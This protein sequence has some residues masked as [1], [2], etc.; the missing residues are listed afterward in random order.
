MKVFTRAV[1]CASISLAIASTFVALSHAETKLD[2]GTQLLLAAPFPGSEA[3]TSLQ[4]SASIRADEIAALIHQ[5]LT[6]EHA[7]TA[8]YA[9]DAI[10]R[11][12]LVRKLLAA[13]GD[14]Y[15]GVWFDP[16]NARLHV[17]LVTAGDS[18]AAEAA[19]TRVGLRFAIAPTYVRSTWVQ[20]KAAQRTWNHRL[21]RLF[22]RAEVETAIAPQHNAVAITLASS[23]PAQDRAAL[24][25][26]AARSRVAT[27]FANAHLP[28]ITIAR[29]AETKC[30]S[31][32]SKL[33]YCNKPITPGVSI[34][35]HNGMRCT[36]GPLVIPK[37]DKARTY[38][39]TA[40][41]CIFWAGRRSP[42]SSWTTGSV[43]LEIGTG[44]EFLL[45]EKGDV[46]AVNVNNPGN[47][48]EAGQTPVFA[49]TA[50]WGKNEEKSF[51]VQGE[52]GPP[53]VGNE[54]CVQGQTSG[55]TCGKIA[56]IG[57]TYNN[58]TVGPIGGLV[59][60]EGAATS[61]PGDSGGP[62]IVATKGG[63]LVEGTDV[64]HKRGRTNAIYEPLETALEDLTGLD[65]ELLTTSNETRPLE[66]KAEKEAGEK[67]ETKETAEK[68][69]EKEKK[70]LEE[71]GEKEQKTEEEEY[72]K[73]QKERKESEGKIKEGNP[74][75]LPAPLPVAPLEFTAASGKVTL[76]AAGG[77]KVECKEGSYTG[78]FTEVR[79][80]TMSLA[81]H[82]CKS[83]GLSCNTLGDT[84]ETILAS[85]K[86]E[87]VDLEKSKLALGFEFS[88]SELNIECPSIKLTITMKGS[89]VGE[90]TGVESEKG[91]K[92]A[93]VVLKQEKGKQAI[94]ECHLTK[95][96]CEGKKFQLEV[97]FGKGLEE[98]GETLE[99]KLAFASEAKVDF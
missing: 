7:R 33:A 15:A 19:A 74:L 14:R 69:S 57:V 81:F 45:G 55:G 29:D 72:E 17:G 4:T 36:A 40:G 82:G 80:G 96:F 95:T 76:E 49:V 99:A 38:L 44:S 27:Q 54:N 37:E 28:Q 52:R 53:T 51:P 16:A 98:A 3:T 58:N 47:W 71:K 9:Q 84:K 91:T 63:Y 94:K 43:L 86:I 11:M 8:V 92:T 48:V 30:K 12:Q 79:E 89:S 34:L 78:S 70:E 42:W 1:L 85:G 64:G 26:E 67:I 32:L 88:P 35:S 21:A 5:G 24:E 66:S 97:N 93:T 22:A 75:I 31:F 18:T 60:D 2:R 50:E 62:V 25:R 10:A 59:E 87:L 65:L 46:G 6:L 13:L 56:L 90:V 20:L 83:S 41:H 68:P 23:V 39:L 61:A 77:G 73:E